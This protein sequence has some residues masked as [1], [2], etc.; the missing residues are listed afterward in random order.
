MELL[1]PQTLISLLTLVLLELVLGID[2]IIFISILAG[3]LPTPALQRRARNV[4]LLLAMG[5]R[6]LLLL[7]ITW[8]IGL[9]AEWFRV[10]GHGFSGRDLILLAGG[11][12]LI[13]KST[14]EIHHKLEHAADGPPVAP[15]VTSLAWV[16]L[17]IVLI[18]IVFSFDSI[19]TAVGLVDDVWVMVVAVIISIGLM[20]LFAGAIG[21]FVDKNPTIKV[22]ALSFLLMIGTLLVAEGFH[23]HFEKGYVYFAMA[24]SLGVEMLNLRVR[25][26]AAVVAPPHS[27]AETPT[28]LSEPNNTVR[29]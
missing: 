18:D 9:Q 22:L 25:R 29:W 13:V 27:E 20:M 5:M 14:S 19:L 8:L 21:R 7:G 15:V 28:G 24:F 6:V 4:G 2:N 10:L 3:K 23:Y 16:L 17:Q 1:Q 12:F 11:L 26:P